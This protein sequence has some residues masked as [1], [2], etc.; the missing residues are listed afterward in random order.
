MVN[1]KAD[2]ASIKRL[3][4]SI[5]KCEVVT[6]IIYLK[7]KY[8]IVPQLSKLDVYLKYIDTMLFNLLQVEYCP[9]V[10]PNDCW[11]LMK[12]MLQ[13]IVGNV[14]ESP[15]SYI[16][17]KMDS[18]YTPSDTINQYLEHFNNFRKSATT[19]QQIR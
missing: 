16:K 13:S 10:I 5:T 18:V 4:I 8:L 19:S 15:P 2:K 6:R 14:A 9:S 1:S 7:E 12:E 17:A 11:N 3:D